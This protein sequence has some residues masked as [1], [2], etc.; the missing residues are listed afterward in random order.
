[1]AEHGLEHERADAGAGGEGGGVSQGDRRLEPRLL[2]GDASAIRLDR[3]QRRREQVFWGVDLL[4]KCLEI[5]GYSCVEGGE[6]L[7]EQAWV[8]C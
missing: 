7:L 6:D 4:R 8:E 5:R 3:G 1:M 2:P